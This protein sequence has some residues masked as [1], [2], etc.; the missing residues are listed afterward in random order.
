MQIHEETLKSQTVLGTLMSRVVQLSP[1]TYAMLAENV[2]V[3]RLEME[4]AIC[5][6]IDILLM[7]KHECAV[8]GRR[9]Y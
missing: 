5:R 9:W 1:N 2:I 8:A 6:M 3:C 4:N 7:F